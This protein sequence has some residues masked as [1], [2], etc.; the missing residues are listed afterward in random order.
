[1]EIEN[2]A[3]LSAKKPVSKGNLGGGGFAKLFILIMLKQ[4]FF[5]RENPN[6]SKVF[7]ICG[8]K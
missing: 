5:C 2:L 7:G 8:T 1:M 3:K 4:S 6:K